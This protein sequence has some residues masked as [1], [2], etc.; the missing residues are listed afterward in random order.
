MMPELP[1]SACQQLRDAPDQSAPI[2]RLSRED[3]PSDTLTL[4]AFLLGKI[5]VRELPEGRVSGRIVETEAYPPGDPAGHAYRGPTPRNK[6]LYL[7]PGHAYVYVCYGTSQMLN[8][9][10]EAAGTGAGVLLRAVVPLEGGAAMQ[11][12]RGCR[13]AVDLTRGPGRLAAAMAIDRRLDGVDLLAAGPLWLGGDGA[14]A[15]RVGRSIRIGLTRGAA[16][17]LRFFV[18]GNPYVSGP[19]RI[20]G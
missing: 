18:A 5:V 11:R 17:A 7:A 3:F 6:S 14:D 13:R 16:A 4:A 8:V 1:S 9:S 15:G 10:S 2:R 12:A 20:N 19:A